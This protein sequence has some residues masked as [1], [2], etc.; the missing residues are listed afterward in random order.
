MIMRVFVVIFCVLIL[1]CSCSYDINEKVCLSISI[2]PHPWEVGGTSLWYTLKWTDGNKVKIRYIDNNERQIKIYTKASQTVMVA[3]YPLGRLNPFG[4]FYLPFSKDTHIQ[5]SQQTGVLV[6][7]FIQLDE[8]CRVSINFKAIKEK[9]DL[10]TTDYRLIDFDILKIDL[11]NDEVD[12][13]SFKVLNKGTIENCIIPSG[14]YIS[15]NVIDGNFFILENKIPKLTI[16]PGW[17]CYYNFEKQIEFK[18][19]FDSKTG[20][21]ITFLRAGILYE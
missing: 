6:S 7:Q 3:L 19:Y 17:H 2:P 11:N 20:K 12:N 18:V 8:F 9:L 16:T 4:G 10:L 5:V 1:V 13:N 14:L 15:E 21:I